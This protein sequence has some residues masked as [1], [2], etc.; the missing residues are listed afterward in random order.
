VLRGVFGTKGDEVTGEGEEELYTLYTSSNIVGINKRMGM[1]W[2]RYVV[3]KGVLEMHTKFWSENHGRH[4]R[5]FEENVTMNL[6][7]IGCDDV[8]WFH[9]TQD[10]DQWR[11]GRLLLTRQLSLGFHTK[12][13]TS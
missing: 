12:R 5:G 2:V 3:R 1:K 7:E 13:G 10:R 6:M 11:T 9:V 8:D 4:T